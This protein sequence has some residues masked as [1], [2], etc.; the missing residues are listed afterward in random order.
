MFIDTH[1]HINS[2]APRAIGDLTSLKSKEYIFIDSS[3]NIKTTVDSLQLS[4][5]YPFIYSAIGFHPFSIKE[6]NETT[7]QD[8]RKIIN[9]NK[10]IVAIGEV[11]L[12]EKAAYNLEEQ[13]KILNQFLLLAKS[14]N[15][16][17]VIHNR[18]SAFD[19]IFDI[20]D[21]HFDSYEDIV[22]HCF[23]YPQS[24]LKK[25]LD[26]QGY[27]SFSANILRKKREIIDSLAYCPLGNL[28]LETDSPYMTIDGSPSI[29]LD[30]VKVYSVASYVKNLNM[31][32]LKK[33]VF[34]N[35]KKVFLT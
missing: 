20:L 35:V 27:V 5:H 25:I 16:T 15:L 9:D 31:K 3:I 23:S 33:T 22:F 8:Y 18:L 7:I 11:G 34:S 2:L 10:K 30:I 17:V 26:K 21:E 12:D 29:P 6:F 13:A 32:E 4:Q 28:L 19:T 1:C 14:V 24:F